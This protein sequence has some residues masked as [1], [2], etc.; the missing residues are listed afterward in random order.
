MTL[1]RKPYAARSCLTKGQAGSAWVSSRSSKTEVS[2]AVEH[3]MAGAAEYRGQKGTQGGGG[4]QV[5]A[6]NG[7]I[8]VVSENVLPSA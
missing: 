7:S 8:P 2:W 3:K 5:G 1:G 6:G 4:K